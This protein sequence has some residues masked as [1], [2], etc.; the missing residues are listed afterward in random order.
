[1]DVSSRTPPRIVAHRG[2]AA[3]YPENTLPSLRSALELGL[4]HVEFDVHLTADH[5]PIVLHDADLLR[6]AG[7]PGNPLEMTWRQLAEIKVG[8]PAR[9]GEAFADVGIPSLHQVT[10]LL[11][12]FPDATAFVE[13]KRASLRTFGHETVVSRVCATLQPVAGQ[14]VIISFD[15]AAVHLA[16]QLAHLPIGWVLSEV[17]ALTALKCEAVR[18]DYLFCNHE[19]L[20]HEETRLW[21]GPW[22][23][24]VY[25]VTSGSQALGLA[26]RGV[27]YV[28][29]MQVR[30][31]LRE[32]RKAGSE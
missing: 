29:T 17:S 20:R 23:W 2:N 15:L 9:F 28:E 1:M 13:L 32:L 7:V 14:C 16:R 18:P 3:E 19:R 8:E 26:A 11:Q 31:L 25:E 24:V 6:T 27:D 4:A 5:V 21:R 10:Q 30:A 12:T 22:S